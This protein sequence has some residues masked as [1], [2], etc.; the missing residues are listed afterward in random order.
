MTRQLLSAGSIIAIVCAGPMAA[1]AA[2]SACERSLQ[3]RC[4]VAVGGT[5]DPRTNRWRVEFADAVSR[6][7]R[8]L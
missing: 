8:Q 7:V 2:P 5:Y 6:P 3:C 4:A 1:Q